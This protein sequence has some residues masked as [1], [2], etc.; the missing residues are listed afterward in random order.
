MA[1]FLCSTLI[2]DH[3]QFLFFPASHFDNLNFPGELF[4]L[5]RFSN[6]LA[7]C[8][9]ERFFFELEENA[10]S[11]LVSPFLLLMLFVSSHS[12]YLQQ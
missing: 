7:Q 5:L 6:S 8:C 4:N 3:L 1:V 2:I 10:V 9:T 11:V 12:H